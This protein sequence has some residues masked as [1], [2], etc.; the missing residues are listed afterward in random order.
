VHTP[1]ML[2]PIVAAEVISDHHVSASRSR[3]AGDSGLTLS[4]RRFRARR[5]PA[6]HASVP[7]GR[8]SFPSAAR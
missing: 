1:S 5:N 6:L 8:P 3:R 7:R 4:L 2:T